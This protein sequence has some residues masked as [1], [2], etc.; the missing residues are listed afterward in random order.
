MMEFWFYIFIY[1]R[2]KRQ[3]HIKVYIFQDKSI[4]NLIYVTEKN[5]HNMYWKFN[6]QISNSPIYNV[7]KN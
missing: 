6:T 2:C 4:L 1:I 7:L 3:L 5:F